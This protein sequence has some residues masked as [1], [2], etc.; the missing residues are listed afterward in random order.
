MQASQIDLLPFCADHLD[1]ALALSQQAGWPHRREDW[2]FVLSVSKGFVAVENGKVVATAMATLYGETCA[3]INMVIVDAAIRGRGLGRKIMDLALDAAKGREC[4]L[5]AT[6][7]GLP[8]YE[9]LGFVAKGEIVQHQGVVASSV[10]APASVAWA[11]PDVT[12]AVI[13]LDSQ[14]FGADRSALFAQ[15]FA[16]GRF[17]VLRDGGQVSG[18]ICLRGFGR[19]EVAGPLVAGS[20]ADAKALLSFVFAECSGRFLRVDTLAATGLAPWLTEHGLA[21]V[22]GGLPMRRALP[23]MA[24]AQPAPVSTFALTSQALG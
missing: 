19:G 17:A 20:L 16:R 23:G 1:G 21:H 22:G 3:T 4:R 2:A 9:K 6:Q 10:T 12:D 8:L 13:A 18:F 11:G 24:E 14:P 7:D 5:V 15:L